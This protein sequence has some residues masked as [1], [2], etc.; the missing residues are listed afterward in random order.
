MVKLIA[1]AFTLVIITMI[2]SCQP[3]APQ[4]APAPAPT[5]PAATLV[6][7]AADGVISPQEYPS[8]KAYGNWEINWR[9]E[10]NDVFIGIRAKTSGWVALGVQ[11]ASG[12]DRADFI[13]GWVADGK[14]TLD[15]QFGQGLNHQPDSR[16]G[17]TNDITIFAGG[18]KDGY[19]VI[20]FRRALDTGDRFDVPLKKG[21]NKILWSFGTG[22]DITRQ[23]AERGY[24]EIS[25]D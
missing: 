23:H 9:S 6:A 13:I 3:A 12:M 15:D 5:A 19:T 18:E 22:D 10:A 16:L 21:T 11:P 25:I 4:P 17:G 7:W 24:G 8:R 20:E 2:A 1:A 14:T